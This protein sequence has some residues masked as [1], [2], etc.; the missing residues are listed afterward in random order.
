[1][2]FTKLPLAVVGATVLLGVFVTAASA[3]RLELSSRTIRATWTDM[4]FSGNLGFIECEVYLAGSFHSSTISKVSGALIGYITEAD[5]NRCSRGGATV[6]RS[7]LPWHRRYRSFGG[8]LPNITE[9]E[10]T[11]TGEEWTLREPTFGLTC[12]IRREHS[13]TIY[14]Q[15]LNR[16]VVVVISVSGTGSPCEGSASVTVFLEGGTNFVEEGGRAELTIRLI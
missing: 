10:E 16:G 15:E 14:R 9:I 11:V 12:T 8:T 3:N 7:S 6:N 1:M 2:N 13:S 5:V 4:T